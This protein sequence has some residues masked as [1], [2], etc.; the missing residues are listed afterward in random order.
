[1]GLSESKFVIQKLSHAC[2]N[3]ESQ[4]SDK[5]DG[6]LQDPLVGLFANT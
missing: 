2:E 3:A 6:F 1:M 5:L 4:G